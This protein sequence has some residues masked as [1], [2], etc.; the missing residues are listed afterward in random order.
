MT[1][2]TYQTK[3]KSREEGPV[4][5]RGSKDT[6]HSDREGRMAGV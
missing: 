1:V 5:A 2:I 3:T 4:L 6:V